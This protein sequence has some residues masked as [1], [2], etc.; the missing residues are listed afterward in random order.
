[1]TRYKS[2]NNTYS[3]KLAYPKVGIWYVDIVRWVQSDTSWLDDSS[4]SSHFESL[5]IPSGRQRATT[6]YD[7]ACVARLSIPL[8]LL[9]ISYTMTYRLCIFCFVYCIVT[10]YTKWTTACRRM[11]IELLYD[12]WIWNITNYV[13]ICLLTLR[14]IVAVF[15]HRNWFIEATMT[16][17][18][19]G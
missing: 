9:S 11:R 4:V 18:F 5:R 14:R 1:M 12:L 16:T 19:H 15:A 13:C 7:D 10:S 17:R 2:I 8:Q 3:C 6:L